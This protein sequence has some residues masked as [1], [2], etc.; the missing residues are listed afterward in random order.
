MKS[1]T[2]FLTVVLL[3]FC[4]LDEI[5]LLDNAIFIRLPNF[6]PVLYHTCQCPISQRKTKINGVSEDLRRI[7]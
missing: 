2:I 5:R 4:T 7:F 3:L 1:K 6:C